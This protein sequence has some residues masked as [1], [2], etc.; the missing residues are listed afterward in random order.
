MKTSSL[1]KKTRRKRKSTAAVVD[2]KHNIA[3]TKMAP[4]TES[5]TINL[6]K[7]TATTS[8][9]ATVATGIKQ[10]RTI[11]KRIISATR[12][13]KDSQTQNRTPRDIPLSE[14]SSPAKPKTVRFKGLTTVP[15]RRNRKKDLS[16]TSPISKRIGVETD[17]YIRSLLRKKEESFSMDSARES[18]LASAA[19][20]QQVDS[21]EA[22]D[23]FIAQEESKPLNMLYNSRS[24][25]MPG[26]KERDNTKRKR[27]YRD[28]IKIA[29]QNSNIEYVETKGSKK[30]RGSESGQAMYKLSRSVPDSLVQFAN[31]IHDVER[32]TPKEEITLGEKTQEALRLQHIYDGLVS[33]LDREPTD[34]EWCAAAGKFNMEAITQTIEEG[35]EAKNKL[36]T[37]NLR[38]VQGVVNVYIRNGL[39]GQYNAG[40]LMQEGILALIRAAEKFDPSRGFRFSTYAMYWIRSAIKRDQLYQS[41]VIQVPQRLHEMKK[42]V[43]VN[44]VQLT[45]SLNRPPTRSELSQAAGMTTTQMDRCE[46]AI[47]QRIFSLDQNM[48]NKNKPMNNVHDQDSLY[49]IISSKADENEYDKVDLLHLREDLIKALKF[50]LSEEEASILI[51]RFGID[52][53]HAS[54]KK[55]GR[56]ISEVSEIVGLKSDKVRRIINRS[57]KQLEI[58][59]G[60]EFQFYKRDFCV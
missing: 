42:R 6:P 16:P 28:G 19:V 8:A 53:E 57:L 33:K 32:I 15:N 45:E 31:E 46:T 9:S 18:P 50:H 38:M 55:V 34:D 37:S 36:V 22:A 21:M 41:R 29:E 30:K 10:E 49:S 12:K 23:L 59:I 39:Q 13:V 5:N 44:R 58:L 48:E 1:T 40:D 35:L 25:T 51:L 43:D 20:S 56:T 17:E 27:L 26:F 24:S 14:T 11:H 4:K 47:S 54:S 2:R 60:E 7:D 52:D 3:T